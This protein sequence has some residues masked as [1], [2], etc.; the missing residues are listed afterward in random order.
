MA[1]RASLTIRRIHKIIKIHIDSLV[2]LTGP[3]F[4]R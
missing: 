1:A 4:T 3:E 2:E